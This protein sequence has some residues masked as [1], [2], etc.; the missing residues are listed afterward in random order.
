MST[1][2]CRTCGTKFPGKDSCKVCGRDPHAPKD[3]IWRAA[4]EQAA[5]SLAIQQQLQVT[6]TTNVNPAMEALT[7]AASATNAA[8]VS[9]SQRQD[10]GPEFRKYVRRVERAKA[11]SRRNQ[12]GRRAVKG[13]R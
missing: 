13:G 5:R 4:R 9:F 11:R 10:L 6:F 8:M 7:R 12:A 1:P 2:T 3:S